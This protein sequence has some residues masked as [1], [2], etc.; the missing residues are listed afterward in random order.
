[1]AAMLATHQVR[2]MRSIRAGGID[3]RR[4]VSDIHQRKE[5]APAGI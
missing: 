3:A 5:F 1:M 4:S 2:G